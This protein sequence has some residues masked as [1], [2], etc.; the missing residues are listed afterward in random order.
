MILKWILKTVYAHWEWDSWSRGL[1]FSG[2]GMCYMEMG[3]DAVRSSTNPFKTFNSNLCWFIVNVDILSVTWCQYWQGSS[4]RTCG[5]FLQD[6]CVLFWQNIKENLKSTRCLLHVHHVATH[7]FLFSFLR[8]E[9]NLHCI[10]N[11]QFVPRSK[12]TL[13]SI[14]VRSKDSQVKTQLVL[15]IFILF[16]VTWWQHVSASITRPSSGHK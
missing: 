1:L 11:M 2:E 9:V 8:T 15:W 10:K 7:N 13:S 4:R 16:K 6:L 5:L 14:Q 3:K 12:H